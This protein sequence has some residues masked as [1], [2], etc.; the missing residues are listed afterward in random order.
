MKTYTPVERHV[1]M[2]A[3]ADGEWIHLED[4]IAV[5]AENALQVK[6]RDVEI[7]R[8]KTFVGQLVDLNKIP[9]DA[10]HFFIDQGFFYKKDGDE[11]M[12]CIAGLSWY[13][14]KLFKNGKLYQSD[15]ISVEMLHA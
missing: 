7:E 11:W 13:P 3:D 15:L 1:T 8:L 6:R 5:V 12:V 14:S 2:E 9:A 4:H 10:T